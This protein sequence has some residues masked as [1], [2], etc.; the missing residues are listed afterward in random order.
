MTTTASQHAQQVATDLG[1]SPDDAMFFQTLPAPLVAA[2][3]RGEVN[4][5]AMAREELQSRGLDLRGE[6]V[7]PEPAADPDQM[8]VDQFVSEEHERLEGF[9]QAWHVAHRDNP[10]QFLLSLP[11]SN[12]GLWGE[13]ANDYE[14]GTVYEVEPVVAIPPRR[15]RGG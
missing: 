11:K 15:P 9:R 1:L 7:G 13:M 10:T 14:L 4:L 8:D 12:W 5:V 6:W 3:A 2:L